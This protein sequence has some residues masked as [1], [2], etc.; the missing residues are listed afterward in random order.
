M[1]R[2]VLP[3]ADAQRSAKP[4]VAYADR[5]WMTTFERLKQLGEGAK[6]GEWKILWIHEDPPWVQIRGNGKNV[7]MVRKGDPL[8]HELK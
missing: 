2:D 3:A 4:R 1:S 7:R 6:L 5:E 8:I